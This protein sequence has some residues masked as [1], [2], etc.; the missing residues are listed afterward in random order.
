MSTLDCF[1]LT[2]VKNTNT[3]SV[4]VHSEAWVCYVS[5]LYDRDFQSIYSQ[6]N[7]RVGVHSYHFSVSKS[8]LLMNLR[9]SVGTPS[10]PIGDRFTV[11][12]LV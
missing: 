11:N 12:L 3:H 9:R 6:D 5:Y 1:Y 2:H 8:D 7:S 10:V 4:S